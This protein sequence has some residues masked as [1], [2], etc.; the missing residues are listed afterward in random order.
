MKGEG[1]QNERSRLAT[2]DVFGT[3]VSCKCSPLS[4]LGYKLEVRLNSKTAPSQEVYKS[5]H[6]WGQKQTKQMKITILHGKDTK[7]SWK[8]VIT[9]PLPH[10]WL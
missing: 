5:F 7:G 2:T 8:K 9:L 3:S 1:K 10:T 6:F 4:S